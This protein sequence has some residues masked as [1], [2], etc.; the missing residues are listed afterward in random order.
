MLVAGATGAP[1]GA[2]VA[3]ELER[4]GRFLPADFAVDF[5]QG[6]P[7]RPTFRTLDRGGVGGFS[8]Y[9][10][11]RVGLSGLA[12]VAEALLSHRSVG[13]GVVRMPLTRAWKAR[14]LVPALARW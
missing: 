3:A 9:A 10:R 7:A 4:G 8:R 12:R 13:R 11:S 5:L 1:L 14:R 2:R 6:R